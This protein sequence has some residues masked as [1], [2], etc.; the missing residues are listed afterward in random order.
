V[1]QC[2]IRIQRKDF[3]K[4]GGGARRKFIPGWDADAN[5]GGGGDVK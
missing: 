3:W 4:L 5:V 1:F 2:E